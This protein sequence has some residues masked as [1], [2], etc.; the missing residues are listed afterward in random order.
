VSF[1]RIFAVLAA[2]CFPCALEATTLRAL[3]E[4]EQIAKAETIFR[5]RAEGVESALEVSGQGRRIFTT[6]RFTPLAVYKGE[7]GG[8]VSLRFLGGRV[9]D[10]EMKV[11]GM[12][13]FEVGGEYVL[14]V[15]GNGNLACPVVGWRD[16]SL[17]VDRRADAA[18]VVAS[19]AKGG[20][21]AGVIARSRK[22]LVGPGQRLPD[23]E[24]RLRARIAALR[25][26]TP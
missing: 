12:P 17:S 21:G 9:G 24:N 2:L 26:K 22:V 23:F 25:E 20:D 16:G 7:A 15:S 8:V 4:D 6:V 5:G 3:T 11:G 1:L 10:L 18:G 13:Q 14:F 19:F